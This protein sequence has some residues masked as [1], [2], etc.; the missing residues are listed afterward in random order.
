MFRPSAPTHNKD[1]KY[2][3]Y[4]GIVPAEFKTAHIRPLLK[5]KNL[6]KQSLKN[7]R[8]VS[9]LPFLS[10]ILEKVIANQLTTIY[11][12]TIY[13]KHFSRPTENLTQ[14]NSPTKGTK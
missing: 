6:D 7:Y 5:K 4:T 11:L 10:K 1:Y 8:P 14:R 13:Q 3:N 9:N 12:K 2:I